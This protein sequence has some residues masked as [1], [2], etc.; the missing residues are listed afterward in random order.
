VNYPKRDY[1]DDAEDY[2]RAYGIEYPPR[3]KMIGGIVGV[4]TIVDCVSNSGSE[5]FNGPYGFVLRDARSIPL[6]P[7]KG[8]LSFFDVPNEVAETLRAWHAKE[9]A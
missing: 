5:W 6:V 2:S 8:A 1:A 4:A 3:E 9:I 7:C